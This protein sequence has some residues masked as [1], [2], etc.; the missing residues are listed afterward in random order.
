MLRYKH[1]MLRELRKYTTGFL[2]KM[3]LILL[4][5][6]FV[7]WGIGDVFQMS[8]T[9][10]Y[11][12]R[13]GNHSIAPTEFQQQL[14]Q[15]LTNYRQL[16]GEE[17]SPELVK[18]LGLPQ[19]VLSEMINRLLL[20]NEAEALGISLSDEQ[21][22]KLTSRD[23]AF[24]GP[25][26]FDKNLFHAALQRS[27]MNEKSYIDS[28]RYRHETG[29]L[30][31]LLDGSSLVQRPLLESLYRLRREMREATLYLFSPESMKPVGNPKEKELH[32]FYQQNENRFKTKEYRKLSYVSLST[33]EVHNSIQI[34]DKT[35]RKQY[36]ARKE[37]F[38][39]P[40]K[41]KLSQLL[42]D[43][44]E[45][46]LSAHALLQ[47][48]KPF[49]QVA[50]QLPPLNKELELGYV[51]NADLIQETREAILQL[52]LGNFSNPIET[53]FG[54]HIFRLDSLEPAVIP[55]LD[56]IAKQLREELIASKLEDRLYNLSIKLEDHLAGGDTLAEAAKDLD[57]KVE[58]SAFFDNMGK[59]D[60][61]KSADLPPVKNIVARAFTGNLETTPEFQMGSDGNYYF[62]TLKETKPSQLP[63]LDAIREQVVALW[64]TETTAKKLANKVHKIGES[65]QKGTVDT[66][67]N[68][69]FRTEKTGKLTRDSEREEKANGAPLPSALRH[70]I[71][72]LPKGKFSRPHQLANGNWVIAK[73]DQTHPLAQETVT[74]ADLASLKNELS[75]QYSEELLQYFLA[76]LAKK[77]PIDVNQAALNQIFKP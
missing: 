74:D 44:K 50:K 69:A 71:F 42:Y 59:T 9:G 43:N 3:L 73:L 21:V 61:N 5:G 56:E 34:S 10:N 17:Y 13:I 20:Q 70:E 23:S 39:T 4:A 22:M 30:M 18:R 46:A 54:W 29:L 72:I 27:G 14:D 2:A 55:N 41:R 48:G 77:Y 58:E 49:S 68:V 35:L 63:K 51:T 33:Q 76:Y 19:Q 65:L 11:L 28:L 26:G 45:K 24:R 40:E 36:E 38:R 52:T 32:A 60:D 66:L 16:L 31:E 15:Q 62:I 7:L 25:K 47:Q 53:T 12:V 57:L 8:G 37:S 67:G 6:S 1:P 64:K 75:E